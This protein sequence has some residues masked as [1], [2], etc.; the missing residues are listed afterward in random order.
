M[1]DWSIPCCLAIKILGK[2]FNHSKDIYVLTV[3]LPP[4]HSTFLKSTNTDPFLLLTQA[5]NKVPPDAFTILMGDFNA[6][7]NQPSGSLPHIHPEI[8]PHLQCNTTTV[9]PPSRISMDH[10]EVDSYGHQLLQFC[11]NRQLTILN[12]C[13]SGDTQGF[14]TYEMGNIRSIIDYSIVSQSLWPLVHNFQ[15]GL[16]NSVLSDHSL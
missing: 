2:V 11:A 3:Y 8:L 10:R 15:I 14:F 6:H 5:Y 4:E 13:T 9:D 1:C 7:T 16:H 12:G